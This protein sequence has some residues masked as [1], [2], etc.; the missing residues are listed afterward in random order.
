MRFKNF[1]KFVDLIGLL[2]QYLEYVHR[3]HTGE[4][5]PLAHIKDLVCS[6]QALTM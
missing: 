3:E 4:E 6:A 2:P 5:L 1:P